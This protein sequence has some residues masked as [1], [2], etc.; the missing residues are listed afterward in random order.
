MIEQITDMPAGAI[1]FRVTE[2]LGD[3]DYADVLAP[4]LR[5]AA[6]AGDVRLLLAAA[7]GFDLMT[8]KG[9]FEA[10]RSDPELDLG[11]SKDWKRV[12]VVAEANFVVRV[13]FPAV[14]KVIPVEVKLFGLGDE[15][16]ARAWVAG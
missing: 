12:A 13:A 8:L 5:E 10:L 16:Q 6:A 9:R 14:A 15:A 7:K 11:H 4:A 3:A 1:G 2:E